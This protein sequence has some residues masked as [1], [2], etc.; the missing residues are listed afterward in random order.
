MLLHLNKVM[1]VSIPPD[2]FMIVWELKIFRRD[3]LIMISL[4]I[5]SLQFM[6]NIVTLIYIFVLSFFEVCD[7]MV[8]KVEY[9]FMIIF[10]K[11]S[12]MLF[13]VYGG[14]WQL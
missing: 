10:I 5:S 1:E 11:L 4:F 6:I 7:I 12:L 2:M 13:L 9:L 8:K 14:L 3:S